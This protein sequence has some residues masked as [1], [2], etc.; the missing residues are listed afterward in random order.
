MKQHVA[1]ALFERGGLVSLVALVVYV[2]ITPSHLSTGDN[3]EFAALAKLGGAAHPPG[4]PL[5]VLWLRALSW[6]PG[7]SPAHTA[8]LATALLGALTVL[9]IHA[10]CRAW[11]FGAHVSSITVAML[12][13]APL[14]VRLHTEAEV[15]ALNG[16]IGASILLLSA[17]RGPLTGFSRVT[18][19]AFV[20]G[21]GLANHHTCVLMAPIGLLGA[22]RGVRESQRPV[23]AVASSVAALALGLTP[24]LYLLAASE[25]RASWGRIDG[26]GALV[27]HFLRMDYGGPA[28]LGPVDRGGTATANLGALLATHARTFLWLPFGAG[29]AALG[30]QLARPTSHDEDGETRAAWLLLLVS[31]LLA[32]PLLVARFNLHPDGVH[33]FITRR[34]H[35]LPVIVLAV[36][37]ALGIQSVATWLDR[38]IGSRRVRAPWQ[39]AVLGSVV[40]TA[41][42]AVTL[43]GIARARSPAIEQALRN[44]LLTLPPRAVVIGT[45]DELH[46]GMGYLQGALGERSDVVVITWQLVGLPHVRKRIAEQLGITIEE[47]P[48]HSKQKLSV[49]VAEQILASGRPLFIDAFQGNIATSFPAYPEGLLYR[50]LPRGS[51]LPS[52]DELFEI[53]QQIFERY[54]FGY[55]FPHRDD[56]VPAYFHTAYADPWQAIA[57]GLEREGK[58]E[59]AETATRMA[60][61]LAPSP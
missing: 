21:L 1:R 48:V 51:A 10:A 37:V 18:A 11:G 56:I 24:Y 60:Q 13:A 30:L 16:L 9:V 38:R 32:G 22:V 2:A 57:A 59:R 31:F 3:A 47:L 44:M 5:Y 8:A 61:T 27:H 28:E 33:A 45:P 23:L 55:E 41:L 43:P 7:D 50:V 17:R 4:Y 49:V 12:A 34:F 35:L 46:F 6:L 20:A 58:R 52:I 15:F 39:S 42:I 53:N 25:T 26:L 36:P 40:M 14:A 54:R 19:L 29:V